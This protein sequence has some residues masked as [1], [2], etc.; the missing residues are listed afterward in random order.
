MA[1]TKNPDPKPTFQVREHIEPHDRHRIFSL[2]NTGGY[3]LP[4]EMAYGM[5]L[6]DEHLMKGD[7]SHYNF[8]LYEHQDA[9]VGYGCYGPIRLSDKRFHLHWLVVDKDYHHQGLGR[10]LEEAIVAKVRSLGGVKIYAE[11]SNR[12]Y[13]KAARAFYEGCGYAPAATIPEYYGDKDDMVFYVK[14]VLYR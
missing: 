5:D 12:D 6:L 3:F 13:H 9:L 7:M 2:L 8:M 1:E 11:T 14:D 4:R 10:V